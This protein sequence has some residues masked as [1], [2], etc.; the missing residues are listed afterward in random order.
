MLAFCHEVK[1][2]MSFEELLL[3]Q[4]Y[5]R[6]DD[7]YLMEA[8]LPEYKDEAHSFQLEFR[9]H[10]L[11]PDFECVFSHDGHRVTATAIYGD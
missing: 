2:G 9:S 1:V 5:H 6:I 3:R 10:M 7:S 4:K 11:D 8:M